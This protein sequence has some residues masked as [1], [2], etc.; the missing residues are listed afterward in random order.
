MMAA[1]KS[2]MVWG[3]C[4]RWVVSRCREP[5]HNIPPRTQ[6]SKTRAPLGAQV[7]SQ[8]AGGLSVPF[9]RPRACGKFIFVGQEKLY[10][11]GVTYGPFRPDENGYEYLDPK[12]VEQDFT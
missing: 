7:K 3:P 2:S 9:S 1:P 10:I 11:R 8:P 4:R 6:T 5:I 12:L